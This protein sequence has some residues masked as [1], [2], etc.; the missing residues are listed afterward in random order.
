MSAGHNSPHVTGRD[1]SRLPLSPRVLSTQ[2]ENS[3]RGFS[4]VRGPQG[5]SSPLATQIGEADPLWQHSA[6]GSTPVY[7][8]PLCAPTPVRHAELT[9]Q[10]AI[11]FGGKTTPPA[12]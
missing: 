3:G 12:L 9:D 6:G 8:Q 10:A 4:R 1:L 2:G 5:C 11:F 7:R